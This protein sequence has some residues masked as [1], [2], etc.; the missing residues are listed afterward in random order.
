MGPGLAESTPGSLILVLQTLRTRPMDQTILFLCP[1]NAAKSV[2][3]T[4]FCQHLA[5]QYGLELHV[6][7]AG[8][9]P[10]P[11]ISPAV[12]ELLRKEGFG[13]ANYRPRAVC[14]EELAAAFRVIS[15]ACDVSDLSPSGTM[16]EHWN[17][18]PAPNQGLS[19]AR[20]HSPG[21]SSD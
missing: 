4:A 5:G 14:R 10:D 13:M 2:M 12:A 19:A 7:S 11:A 1:H 15:M 21:M 18:V 3:A 8:T 17:D 20:D 16:V 9:E 6:T